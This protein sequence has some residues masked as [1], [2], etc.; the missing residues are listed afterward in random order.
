[1]RFSL[2]WLVLVCAAC[3]PPDPLRIPRVNA[4]SC[5]SEA[6]GDS[7]AA[8]T[9]YR[10]LSGA[11]SPRRRATAPQLVEAVYDSTGRLQQLASVTEVN[12]DDGSLATEVLWVR[13]E[14]NDAVRAS[15]VR[16]SAVETPDFDDHARRMHER[17]SGPAYIPRIA[18]LRRDEQRTE[19]LPAEE[20]EKVRALG[21]FFSR[22]RCGGRDLLSGISPER[23]VQGRRSGRL[24]VDDRAV[25]GRHALILGRA[26]FV[27]IRR[28]AS[29]G[30]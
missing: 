25:G 28:R 23:G 9:V 2:L 22:L 27:P 8:D 4:I 30:R 6:F 16:F 15:R 26:P 10:W 5:A 29:F 21:V 19:T 1:M 7:A 20:I 14:P 13:L 11:Y 12:T 18:R 24:H 17:Y 3:E